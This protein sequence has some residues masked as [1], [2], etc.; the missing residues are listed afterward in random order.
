MKGSTIRILGVGTKRDVDVCVNPP[1]L[2]IMRFLSKR[3]AASDYNDRISRRLT[4]CGI[5]LR[6]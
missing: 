3:G 1:T 2:K 5:Q 4:R 6:K